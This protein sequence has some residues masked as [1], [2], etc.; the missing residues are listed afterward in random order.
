M[1][2]DHVVAAK[3]MFAGGGDVE[4]AGEITT[5]G[6]ARGDRQAPTRARPNEGPYR[7]PCETSHPR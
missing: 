4:Q 6:S 7:E 3:V 2:D 5:G 1:G